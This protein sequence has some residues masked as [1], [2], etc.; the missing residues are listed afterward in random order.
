MNHCAVSVAP[1]SQ[2]VCKEPAEIFRALTVTCADEP[3]EFIVPYNPIE[4]RPKD[5]RSRGIFREWKRADQTIDHIIFSGVAPN[6]TSGPIW[7][8]R[9]A[10]GRKSA[11]TRRLRKH[12]LRQNLSIC[13]GFHCSDSSGMG[14]SGA[15]PGPTVDSQCRE[16]EAIFPRFVYEKTTGQGSQNLS[17]RIDV[18]DSERVTAYRSR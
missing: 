10:P 8:D 16:C 15:Q 13:G 17:H 3:D 6:V 9:L 5:R 18:A 2:D 11:R 14:A 4:V 1:N 12:S 7:K